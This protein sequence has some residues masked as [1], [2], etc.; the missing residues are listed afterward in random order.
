MAI[1]LGKRSNYEMLAYL[2]F[3]EETKFRS[4]ISLQKISLICF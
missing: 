4:T 1:Q 2:Q 3:K